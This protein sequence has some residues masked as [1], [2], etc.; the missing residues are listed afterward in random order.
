MQ[1]Q[2]PSCDTA[3]AKVSWHLALVAKAAAE[4]NAEF[5]AASY[6]Q[7]WG[8]SRARPPSKC[9]EKGLPLAITSNSPVRLAAPTT[10]CCTCAFVTT[11][12]AAGHAAHDHQYCSLAHALAAMVAA[13][14]CCGTATRDQGSGPC[15]IERLMRA[16]DLRGSLL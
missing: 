1:S 11:M 7:T 15:S 10:R 5:D 2:R 16:K 6:L 12:L 4:T 3:S 14:L 9:E 13:E 8:S